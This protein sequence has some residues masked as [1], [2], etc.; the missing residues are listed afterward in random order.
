MRLLLT[1]ATAVSLTVISA[2]AQDAPTN[3]EEWA[4]ALY[5]HLLKFKSIYVR[6]SGNVVVQ[7]IVDRTGD[8]VWAAIAKSSGDPVIDDAALAL[9]RHARPLPV[10]PP[11]VTDEQLHVIVQIRY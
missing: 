8:L 3:R 4:R 9:V 5:V 10:P 11:S 7:F 1:I 2:L 6:H